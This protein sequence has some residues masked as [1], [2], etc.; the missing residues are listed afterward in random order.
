VK[1]SGGLPCSNC[2][3]AGKGDGCKYP[4]RD[5]RVKLNESYLEELLKE[6]ELLRSGAANPSTVHDSNASEPVQT[7]VAQD[8][9]Q[10]PLFGER[11]WFHPVASLDMPI[12]IDLAADAAF[13]TR[14]RQ[15]LAGDSIKHIPRMNFVSDDV[16]LALSETDCPW[17]SPARSRFLVKVALAT[18]CRSYHM[19]RRSEVLSLLE[20]TLQNQ[21]NSNRLSVSKL[22]ALFALGELHATKIA[23]SDASFPGLLFFSCSR[24]MVTVPAERPQSDTLEITLLLVRFYL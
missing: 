22:F 2:S 9:A 16:I 3:Q 13:A 24:K 20:T 15:T 6:N 18:V 14:F 19:V 7:G 12:H 4:L 5:R 21:G 8:A 1:C 17:P 10:N 11:P 23:P